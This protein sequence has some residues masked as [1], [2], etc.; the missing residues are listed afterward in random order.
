ML[1][2]KTRARAE[3]GGKEGKSHWGEERQNGRKR[4][5]HHS[6]VRRKIK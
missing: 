4:S 3:A 5:N 6:S 2:D 1:G